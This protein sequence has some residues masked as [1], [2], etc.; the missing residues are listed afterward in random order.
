ML[1]RH[2]EGQAFP[3]NLPA[4]LGKWTRA[5]VFCL[6]LD[7]VIVLLVEFNVPTSLILLPPP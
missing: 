7:D 2:S 6:F 1:L 3:L 5:V 4:R